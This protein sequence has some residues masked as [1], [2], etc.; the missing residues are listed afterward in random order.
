MQ[1]IV[2]A[3]NSFEQHLL[4]KAFF[5][6]SP[7]GA[8]IE[9]IPACNM[10]CRMCYVR[11]DMAEVNRMGGLMDAEFWIRLGND[12]KNMGTLFVLLTGGEPLMYPH[13]KEVYKV[14]HDLGF[15]LTVNT[16]G[17]LLNEEWADF[18]A[19][20]PPRRLN[21]TLYGKDNET[22]DRLCRNPK[23]FDQICNAS[24]LLRERNI[25]FRLNTSLTPYN[26]TQLNNFRR[27]AEEWGV[28]LEAAT[29]MMPP[30]RKMTHSLPEMGKDTSLDLSAVEERLK[31]HN[32]N[33]LPPEKAAELTFDVNTYHVSAEAVKEYVLRKIS[34]AENFTPPAAYSKGYTCRAGSAG[35]WVKWD[36]TMTACG[37]QGDKNLDL[38]NS[39]FEDSWKKLVQQTNTAELAE[40]CQKCR[41]Q[42][43]CPHCASAEI[44]EN[45]R[46]GRKTEYLCRYAEAYYE[47]LKRKAKEY[48]EVLQNS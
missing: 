9:L 18:F 3:E 45:G 16:N 10:D 34:E 28:S 30:N 22:Y 29:Y 15:V 37:M 25:P 27:I 44:T 17:T 1:A 46:Y 47:I 35:F 4:D 11:T 43:F 26:Y 2:G 24:K 20:Y 7:I 39:T 8:N 23:G 21:I 19:L 13:F 14:Y 41:L 42:T 6:R 48:E 12:M 5:L 38:K 36:G 40:E 31:N 32:F 33:R